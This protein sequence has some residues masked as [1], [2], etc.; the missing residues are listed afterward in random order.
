MR[1]NIKPENRRLLEALDYL[2]DGVISSVLAE[3]KVPEEGLQG[4]DKAATRRSIK[5]ALALA[6]CL[7]LISAVIPVVSF[8]S[9]RF[10][11]GSS[12]TYE[13]TYPMFVADLEP[14]S[15]EEM[16]KINEVYED[17]KYEQ[18]YERYISSDGNDPEQADEYARSLLGDDPHRFFN[19]ERY[20]NYQYYGKFGDCVV[21]ATQDNRYVLMNSRV[22][23]YEFELG[24]STAGLVVYRD[25]EMMTLHEAYDAG[26]MTDAQVGAAHE[27]HLAYMEY[28]DSPVEKEAEIAIPDYT[29]P[30]TTSM[31]TYWDY[32]PDL[33][34]L[35][36]EQMTEIREAYAKYT[37]ADQYVKYC[38]Q[39]IARGENYDFGSAYKNAENAAVKGM[40]ALFT[41]DYY[42]SRYYG[43]FGD[44]VVVALV[45]YTLAATEY[46]LKDASIV[47]PQG[48]EM[49]VYSDGEI[50]EFGEFYKSGLMSDEDALRLWYRHQIYESTSRSS[51]EYQDGSYLEPIS[52]VE[53]LTRKQISEIRT[54]YAN[55]VYN[56]VLDQYTADYIAQYGEEEG[57]RTVLIK[58]GDALHAAVKSLFGNDLSASQ[59]Y[60]I[61]DGY[62]IFGIPDPLSFPEIPLSSGISVYVYSFDFDMVFKYS[63]NMLSEDGV[64][65]LEQRQFEYAEYLLSA[66][67]ESIMKRYFGK[68]LYDDEHPLVFTHQTD[69]C[70]L[71]GV[72]SGYEELKKYDI[73]GY[74]FVFPYGVNLYVG[75]NGETHSL[76]GAHQIGYIT[77][78]DMAEIYEAY[79]D[80][81]EKEN[82]S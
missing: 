61:I 80:Y 8:L 63:P 74:E 77:D 2:D 5:Y 18:L 9:E 46:R 44:S 28:L 24:G 3:I 34:P 22:A 19:K 36:R 33:E 39:Y 66:P 75:C 23:G 31:P 38:K 43:T 47:F 45:D 53:P 21:L 57:R 71:I 16:M 73:A 42:Y 79:L 27:R 37:F 35:S 59:Y 82:K 40:K 68:V 30:K 14:L 48:A 26:F 56:T 54:A 55:Y 11:A 64:K 1:T 7:V 51:F 60:G 49:Y 69:R 6:A 76:Y 70:M 10:G 52:G 15:E 32:L 50:T 25:G 65:K 62:V 17:W 29:P 72:K 13:L 67:F 81:Y 4:R 20:R 41:D 12:K 58:A 78:A